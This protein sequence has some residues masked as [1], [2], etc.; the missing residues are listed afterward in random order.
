MVRK[1]IKDLEALVDAAPVD[2]PIQTLVSRDDLY[3]NVTAPIM[4]LTVDDMI[5][6]LADSDGLVTVTVLVSHDSFYAGATVRLPPSER[7]VS[8]IISG[9]V[10]A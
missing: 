2:E 10:E 6:D 7:L 5:K 1:S 4:G 9:W 3:N 8:M